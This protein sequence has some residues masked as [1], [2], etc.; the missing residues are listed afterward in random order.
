MTPKPRIAGL[1]PSLSSTGISTEKGTYTVTFSSKRPP[2]IGDA[3]D[4]LRTRILVIQGEVAKACWPADVVFIEGFSRGSIQKREELGHL[5][6]EIRKTLSN[7]GVPYVDIAPTV[8]KK[9][10]TGKGNASKEEVFSA[11]VQLLGLSPSAKDDEAD[12]L[13]LRELGRHMYGVSSRM[14]PSTH[15]DH[16][17]KIEIPEIER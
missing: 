8:L 6:Y 14:P 16:L 12:A 7:L 9:F 1:D 2:R 15:T 17:R 11:A 13:W 3:D 5:G 10:A 4:W